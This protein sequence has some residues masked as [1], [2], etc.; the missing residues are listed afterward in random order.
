MDYPPSL[1]YILWKMWKL[2]VF[3]EI[4]EKCT[5]TGW[6]RI[7]NRHDF[8]GKLPHSYLLTWFHIL[9]TA[10]GPGIVLWLFFVSI[11]LQLA[12]K[13]KLWAF[14]CGLGGISLIG[15]TGAK[16]PVA[17]RSIFR[18]FLWTLIESRFFTEYASNFVENPCMDFNWCSKKF[19]WL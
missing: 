14:K 2:W 6:R 18:I 11:F 19:V 12:P 7:R 3:K 13:V 1:K 4:G 15:G 17:W 5:S 8:F 10:L 9:I 16:Q